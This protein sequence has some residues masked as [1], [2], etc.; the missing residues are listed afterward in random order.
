MNTEK[1]NKKIIEKKDEI[2]KWRKDLGR[3]EL[4]EK[5]IIRN[6]MYRVFTENNIIIIDNEIK[7][8]ENNTFYPGTIMGCGAL[9]TNDNVIYPNTVLHKNWRGKTGNLYY[10]GSPGRTIDVKDKY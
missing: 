1:I 5:I 3:E 7:I 2:K 10:Q 6:A 9:S 4:D 8:G